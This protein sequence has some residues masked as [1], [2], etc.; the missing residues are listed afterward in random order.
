MVYSWL[1]QPN[2]SYSN[3]MRRVEKIFPSLKPK[4]MIFD[5]FWNKE[6]Q[7]IFQYG[8]FYG[9]STAEAII[10][11]PINKYGIAE[12]KIQEIYMNEVEKDNENMKKAIMDLFMNLPR[13]K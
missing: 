3:I 2:D 9:I 10:A 13:K 5:Q 6:R 8:D 12:S 4:G 7:T 1:Q 11:V